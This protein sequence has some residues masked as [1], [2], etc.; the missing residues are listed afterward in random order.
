[1]PKTKQRKP[2][3]TNVRIDQIDKDIL[4]KLAAETG[5][6]TPKLLHRAI[7]Q[8]KRKLFFEKMNRSYRQI[9]ENDPKLWNKLQEEQDL[10]ENAARDGLKGME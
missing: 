10:F 3:Q 4:D 9:R 6:S 2:P 1:M 5:E 8:L 7:D